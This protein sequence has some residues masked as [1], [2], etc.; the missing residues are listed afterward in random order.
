MHV[1]QALNEG[2]AFIVPDSEIEIIEQLNESMQI[3]ESENANEIKPTVARQA[4]LIE[5]SE[6]K[7]SEN[8]SSN[9]VN[10]LFSAS[11]EECENF[12][13]IFGA[14][15]LS[16]KNVSNVMLRRNLARASSH[17]K[18]TFDSAEYFISKNPDRLRK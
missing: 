17:Q 7:K 4:K 15:E 6:F 12:L 18:R 5:N 14:S 2:I 10:V 11:K 1:V 16:N 13:K 8:L 3:N 9:D